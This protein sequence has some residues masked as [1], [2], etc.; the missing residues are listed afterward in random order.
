MSKFILGTANFGGVYGISQEEKINKQQLAYIVSCAQ[1]NGI[2]HFDTASAYDDAQ[3][4]LGELLDHSRDIKIDSKISD[5]ECQTVNSIVES[6]KKSINDLKVNKL[7]TL[8]LHNSDTLLG[9][10]KNVT[11]AGLLK[12]IQSGLAERIGV[13]AYTLNEV[14]A[15]K[16]FFP[17]LTRFQVPEN[18]CD[19]RLF[20]SL[21]LEE[22][23]RNGTEIYIRSIFL[24]GL[25]LMPGSAI[26]LA[27]HKA[28]KCI[29]DLDLYSELNRV[30]KVDLCIAYAKTVSWASKAVIGVDSE[31]QL[32]E[33]IKSDIKLVD[34]WER[35]ISTLSESV[36]DPRNWEK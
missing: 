17:E 4:T 18:I 16:F 30:S 19:R 24:Q 15:C 31:S 26:P 28:K 32:Q 34:G 23:S 13:S 9:A 2:N 1:K 22:I 36:V 14:V 29:D 35:T 21:D 5:K 8:Y 7:S 11:K 25:L 6:V 10:N 33:I 20:N 12:V 27:L 3:K